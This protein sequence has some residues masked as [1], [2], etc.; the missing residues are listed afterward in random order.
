M[1][2]SALEVLKSDKTPHRIGAKGAIRGVVTSMQ[3]GNNTVRMLSERAG[4]WSCGFKAILNRIL[5][6]QETR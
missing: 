4:V 1:P 2:L 6:G 3:I 5:R